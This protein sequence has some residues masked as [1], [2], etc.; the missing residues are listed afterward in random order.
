MV[1]KNYQA[2]IKKPEKC[3]R[4]I[5]T[6]QHASLKYSTELVREIKG[7]NVKRA[8]SF[9]QNILEKKE[10]LPLRRYVKQVGHRKGRSRSFAKT[11]R[12]PKGTAEIFKKLIESAKANADYKGLDTE[13]LIIT[14][15]FA[16]QGFRRISHQSQG[17]ITG[18]RRGKKSVHLEIVVREGK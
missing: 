9:L 8:E 10:F 4:V 16:S 14:H 7:K 2:E 5:M 15:A 6:N 11:G 18:K 13:N 1:K 17:R 3:A 12:Y